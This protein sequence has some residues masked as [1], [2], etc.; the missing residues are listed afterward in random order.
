MCVR[1]ARLA[2]DPCRATAVTIANLTHRI[3][4]FVHIWRVFLLQPSCSGVFIVRVFS[5]CRGAEMVENAPGTL[6]WLYMSRPLRSRTGHA[7]TTLPPEALYTDLVKEDL[8]TALDQN[9]GDP[10]LAG[11]TRAS[12]AKDWHDALGKNGGQIGGLAV[13]KAHRIPSVADILS[14]NE[15]ILHDFWNA[16]RFGDAPYLT[17]TVVRAARLRTPH[18]V[19]LSAIRTVPRSMFFSG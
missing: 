6:C 13:V 10:A 7:R 15:E 4:M 19:H 3:K 14:V 11:L 2:K 5:A 18:S 17:V 1:G 16:T 9:A 12:A 8:G